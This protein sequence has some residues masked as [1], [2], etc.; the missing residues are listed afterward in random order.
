MLLAASIFGYRN[1]DG[2]LLPEHCVSYGIKTIGTI[3]DDDLTCCIPTKDGGVFLGGD[4]YNYKTFIFTPVLFK[5][6]KKGNILWSDTSNINTFTSPYHIQY[7]T[8]SDGG[9]IMLGDSVAD[10]YN[11]FIKL[12][13]LEATGSI[14]WHT[15]IPR[16]DVHYEFVKTIKQTSDGG[17]VLSGQ[18]GGN[19]Y[20]QTEA[21]PYI[22]KTDQNGNVL[23]K[24][25]YPSIGKGNSH[26]SHQSFEI[27]NDK[28]NGFVLYGKYA[29][30]NNFYD[31]ADYEVEYF[32]NWHSR[33]YKLDS[34]GNILWNAD[35]FLYVV[36]E[37]EKGNSMFGDNFYINPNK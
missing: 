8:T 23:W 3:S 32:L 13:K 1:T 18:Y 31:E 37:E 10:Y 5:L 19:D 22:I 12:I 17:F 35:E 20:Y 27:L 26:V 33:F 7:D 2:I 16:D 21:Y 34:Q 36:V 28:N 11:H 9:F 30:D 14:Q 29:T 6:D 25:K 15:A 24:K 4:R